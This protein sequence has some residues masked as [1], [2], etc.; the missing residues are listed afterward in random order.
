MKKGIDLLN[1]TAQCAIQSVI[2]RAKPCPFC[3]SKPKIHYDFD[4]FHD[5]E[6]YIQC[7]GCG[8]VFNDSWGTYHTSDLEK[9]VDKWNVRHVL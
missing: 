1:E 4:S 9:E 8:L 6:Y 2:E 3:G 7:G 5:I